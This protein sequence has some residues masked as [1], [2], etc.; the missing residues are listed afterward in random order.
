MNWD[1]DTLSGVAGGGLFRDQH[2]RG[3]MAAAARSIQSFGPS[4]TYL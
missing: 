3:Q 1:I 2:G 4:E